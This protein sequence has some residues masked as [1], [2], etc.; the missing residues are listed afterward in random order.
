MATISDEIKRI[1]GAKASIKSSIENKG[2]TVP[3]DAHLEEYPSYINKIQGGEC[4][5]KTSDCVKEL[6][7]DMYGLPKKVV[8]D[9][10]NVISFR[11]YYLDELEELTFGDN[12]KNIE[13]NNIPNSSYNIKVTYGKN[14]SSIG[15]N[16]SGYS[17]T[18]LGE[19]PP[20]NFVSG[21]SLYM[22]PIY[23]PET[24]VDTYKNAGPSVANRIVPIGWEY[25]YSKGTE[26]R[27]S[28][29]TGS[30]NFVVSEATTLYSASTM[31]GL[32]SSKNLRWVYIGDNVDTITS[33]TF[34][35]GTYSSKV[36]IH[37]SDNSN[38]KTVN[39]SGFTCSSSYPLLIYGSPKK[40]ESIGDR[41][42]QGVTFVN[43]DLYLGEG[44]TEIGNYAFSGATL[45]DVYY[46]SA[47]DVGG[48]NIFR[49]AK[50]NKLTIGQNAIKV[51]KNLLYY[52]YATDVEM[53]DRD[54]GIELGVGAF[55]F[56]SY[57]KKV[58]LSN[59]TK[60]NSDTLYGCNKIEE[61]VLKNCSV[62][63]WGSSSLSGWNPD[64]TKLKIFVDDDKVDS[65]KTN[66]Y[67][68]S[69]SDCIYPLS[70]K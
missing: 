56:A 58:K 59:V 53:E 21:C 22:S 17:Q 50:M 23:V 2:V 1:Q 29:Q 51:P 46:D 60:T 4:N 14:V 61:L 48:E 34:T 15:S 37:F 52:S 36:R 70:S 54:I 27:F 28:N 68:G 8:Y 13:S 67:W 66:Q 45:N 9:C 32:S 18:F 12:V 7:T 57:L 63:V 19:T 10:E 26:V 69:Y 5:C 6:E 64:K 49:D 35:G 3:S 38:L 31:T 25:D 55:M 33:R 62:E 39:A 30:T 24:A 11:Y 43:D 42:F 16:T 47:Y 40:M 65:F 44:I 41:A 20:T